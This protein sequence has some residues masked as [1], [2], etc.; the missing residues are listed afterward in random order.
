MA[1]QQQHSDSLIGSQMPF[2]LRLRDWVFGNEKPDMY[3]QASFYMNMIIW[4]IFFFWSIAS[5]AAITFRQ[6]IFEQ[7]NIPVELII[8]ARG[9]KLGFEP[10]DFLDRLLTFHAISIICWLAVFVG[11]VLMWRKDLR[12]VYFHFGGTL[13]YFGMLIFYLSFGYYKEDTT[14]FDKVTFLAMNVNAVMYY[15]LLKREKSGGSLSFF[16]EE[17]DEE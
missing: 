9:I 12:F 7:K 16:G 11:L 4:F 8:K 10:T 17:D 14:F 3:T 6:L 1:T 5:Y 15:I 13:F 2:L